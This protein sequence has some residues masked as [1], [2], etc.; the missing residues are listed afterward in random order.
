MSLSA[1]IGADGQCV[2][3]RT[4]RKIHQWPLN[5]G[6]GVLQEIY[7][8]NEVAELGLRLLSA[9]GH[10]GP[11]TVEFRQN[12]RN[13][14]FVLIEINAR[15]IMVQEMITRSG[16]DVPLIAYHDAM[17]L[18][19]PVPGPVVPVRWI[20]LGG[21]FRAFRQMRRAGS[22]TLWTWLR[23]VVTCNVFAYLAVDDPA[24]FLERVRAWLVRQV[25]LSD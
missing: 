6:D 4:K 7:E 20:H 16:L 5:A 17:S 3:W 15:T 22:I 21:D 1:Y 8:Q 12:E 19:L 11:A 14:R 2:G 24:P 10:R 23:I 18:P 25:R 9:L 13:G